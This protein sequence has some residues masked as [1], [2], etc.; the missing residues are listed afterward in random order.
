[1]ALDCPPD[2]TWFDDLPGS[3]EHWKR[4]SKKNSSIVSVNEMEA[5]PV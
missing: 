4:P 3:E 5:E 2:A 1:M